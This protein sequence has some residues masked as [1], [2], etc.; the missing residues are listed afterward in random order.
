MVAEERAGADTDSAASS[1]HGSPR[2]DP[3][4]SKTEERSHAPR[5]MFCLLRGFHISHAIPISLTSKEESKIT[6]R[7]FFYKNWPGLE[8]NASPSATRLPTPGRTVGLASPHF[9]V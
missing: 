8:Q 6:D 1:E 9:E 4:P 5:S 2:R 7:I 3:S